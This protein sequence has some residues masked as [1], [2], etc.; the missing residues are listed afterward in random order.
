MKTVTEGWKMLG[1]GGVDRRQERIRRR[2]PTAESQNKNWKTDERSVHA[3]FSQ[4]KVPSCSTV[5]REGRKV[6]MYIG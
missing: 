3:I 4:K 2:N 1:N 5:Y 6:N